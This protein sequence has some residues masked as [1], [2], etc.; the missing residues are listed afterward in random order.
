M[1]DIDGYRW[2]Q[3]DIVGIRI[4]QAFELIAE[5]EELMLL[6]LFGRKLFCQFVYNSE[7][8][9][10]VIYHIDLRCVPICDGYFFQVK[11]GQGQPALH[12]RT[13][14]ERERDNVGLLN[15]RLTDIHRLLTIH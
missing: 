13:K 2:I 11:V 10:H 9:K 6:A 3:Y 12:M 5:V 7:K 8:N 15:R 4:Y 14:R 1:A